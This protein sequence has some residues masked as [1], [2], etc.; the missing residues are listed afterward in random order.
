MLTIRTWRDLEPYGIISLTGEACKLGIRM[1]CDLTNDGVN[2]I[3][4]VFGLRG[5]DCLAENWNSTGVKSILLPYS[6]FN[7]LA[8][9]CLILGA[10]CACA[11]IDSQSKAVHGFVSLEEYEERGKLL[12]DAGIRFT[13]VYRALNHPGDGVNATHAFTGRTM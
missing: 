7:D 5:G 12:S 11:A 3:G 13:R 4:R 9:C 8:A 2:I 6:I 1:L 10:D